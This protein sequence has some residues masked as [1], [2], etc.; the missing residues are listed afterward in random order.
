MRMGRRKTWTVGSDAS[1]SA[2]AGCQ[3]RGIWEKW[4][5]LLVVAGSTVLR[6]LLLL[7]QFLPPARSKFRSNRCLVMRIPEDKEAA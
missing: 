1:A 3:T 4:V 5:N 7:A 2:E 6:L